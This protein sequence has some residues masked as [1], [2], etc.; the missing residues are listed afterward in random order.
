MSE[1]TAVPRVSFEEYAQTFRARVLGAV[2]ILFAG[3]ALI[4]FSGC[5]MIGIL[6]ALNPDMDTVTPLNMSPAKKSMLYALSVMAG[7]CF[8]SGMLLVGK[9]FISTSKAISERP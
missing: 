1:S 8:I 2:A 9:G 3:L 7:I 5:F 6:I 4:F